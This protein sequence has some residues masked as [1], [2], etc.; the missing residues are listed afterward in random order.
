MKAKLTKDVAI[1]VLGT[2]KTIKQGTVISVRAYRFMAFPWIGTSE[3]GA[4]GLHHSDI[5]IPQSEWSDI[6]DGYVTAALWSS[7]D[8]EGNP[9]DGKYVA[10][11]IALE[12]RAR[13][14][15]DA[16]VFRAQFGSVWE[17]EDTHPASGR[18][19]LDELAG[20]DL[21]L[22]RNG[23]G[24][25]FWDGD[26]SEEVGN[27]LTEEAKKLGECHLIVGDDGLIWCE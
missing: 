14:V 12:A 8:D 2:I 26:W 23:H 11:D 16:E 17:D 18:S 27:K 20:H 19:S 25:G 22:T 15:H 9:M 10:E 24:A 1:S 5:D 3:Y 4:V 7:N 13:L 6:A 21:W